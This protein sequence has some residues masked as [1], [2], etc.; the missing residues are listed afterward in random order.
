MN[1]RF[2]ED[3]PAIL[4]VE[5]VN[6]VGTFRSFLAKLPGTRK[7]SKDQE[8]L[9]LPLGGNTL[10]NGSREGE[11]REF[12][13][14]NHPKFVAVIDSERSGPDDP[15][16]KAHAAFK[17]LCDRIGLP[18]YVLERRSIECY[19]TDQAIKSVY[20][21]GF[22]AFGHFGTQPYGWH[23]QQNARVAAAM[24]IEDLAGTDLDRI[25]REL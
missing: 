14:L 6:D 22:S 1:D 4:L 17:D 23:N 8:F 24:S 21:P 10:V 2:D 16:D 7:P 13:Q 18:C 9:I 5:G 11:L 12:T 20:G 19:F 15:P 3:V 25:L